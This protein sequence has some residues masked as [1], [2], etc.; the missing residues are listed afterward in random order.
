[1][2]Q[3]WVMAMADGDQ[4]RGTDLA[5]CRALLRSGSRSFHLASL[6]LP[7]RVSEAATALYAFCRLADD[8]IDMPVAAASMALDELRAQLDRVYG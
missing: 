8:A 5:A 6:L 1:M 2:G 4:Q 3:P 7:R